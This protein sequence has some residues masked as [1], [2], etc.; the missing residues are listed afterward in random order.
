MTAPNDS[1]RDIFSRR[2]APAEESAGDSPAS[3]LVTIVVG[4]DDY[5][6][7]AVPDLTCAVNDAE[8]VANAIQQTQPG[9]ALDLIVLTAPAREAGVEVPTKA[10]ILEALRRAAAI[11]GADDTILFYFAG[12]GGMMGQHPCLFPADLGLAHGN[13]GPELDSAVQVEELQ[14]LFDDCP[15][16]R[17]V[18]CLDCCQ[19]GFPDGQG[20]GPLEAFPAGRALQWR[21][22]L[23]VT[24]G[25][26]EAFGHLSG[27]WSILLACSPNELSLEDPDWGQHGI[28]SHFLAAGLRG[29]ADLD[30]DGVVSLAE[31]VQYLAGRVR[32]QARAVIEEWKRP[33][34]AEP[35]QRDQ[36][37][38]LLWGGPIAF[39][40]TRAIAEGRESFHPRV[41]ALWRR[42][43]CR[44]F[45]YPMA[46]EGMM[47]YGLALLYGLAL[48]LAVLLFAP[49]GD[50]FFWRS[51]AIGS[52]LLGGLIWL[53]TVALSVAANQVRWHSGGYVATVITLIW[54][55]ILFGLLLVL[56][57]PSEQPGEMLEPAFRLATDLAVLISLMV[58]FGYNAVHGIIAL[59]DLVK[60]DERVVLRRVFAHLDRQWIHADIPN[61]I[62]LVSGHPKLYLVVGLGCSLLVLAHAVYLLAAVPFG[63]HVAT[64]VARD[65]VLI[66][67]IQ[68][69]VTWFSAAYRMLRG[70]VLP[71]R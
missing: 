30:G 62:P 5:R 54:H 71:E 53:A 33:D 48:A 35:P 39:P 63:G 31:L 7:E 67:L 58:I 17:R 10:N 26:V 25:L 49:S 2:T 69:Q 37:P 36:N 70:L 65:F 13:S 6:H 41:L 21:T 56:R 27:D 3:R 9:D 22:G 43:L 14:A 19:S 64:G 60:K 66:V 46:L 16:R 28:F 15:C 61:V 18:M 59:A 24:A 12:H 11:A 1:Y 57:G 23:P 4:V 55:G 29:E 32:K 52:G 42:N 34:R 51:M 68:W 44:P 45:P 20:P 38:T 40:L 8:S 50:A 47:R